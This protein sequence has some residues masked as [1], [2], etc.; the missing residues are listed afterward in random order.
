MTGVRPVCH[1]QGDGLIVSSH[2]LEHQGALLWHF[3]ARPG[4]HVSY[5]TPDVR[6][7]DGQSGPKAGLSL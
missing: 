5:Y 3:R 1:K 6:S 2:T 7:V 4:L